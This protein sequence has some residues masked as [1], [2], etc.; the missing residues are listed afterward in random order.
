MAIASYFLVAGEGRPPDRLRPSSIL[1]KTALAL[2]VTSMVFFH[3]YWASPFRTVDRDFQMSCYHA[4]AL[5]KSS[6][7]SG[8]NLVSIG[9][10]P[11]PEH[12]IGFEVGVYV[13]YLTDRNLAAMNSALPVGRESDDQL[14]QAVLGKKS[15]AVLIWGKP[16]NLSYQTIVDRLR[17]AQGASLDEAILDPQMG[18]V[19][20]VVFFSRR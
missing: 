11:Y 18:E 4:A 15:D 2:L 20:R 12:G 9:N 13:A 19:G 10:G 5:L 1:R 16:G 8:K 7:P 14:A 17:S 6:Q 3:L